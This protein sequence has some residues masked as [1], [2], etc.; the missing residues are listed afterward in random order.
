MRSEENEK[1]LINYEMKI[2]DENKIYILWH[3]T[4]LLDRSNLK[5]V[6][7]LHIEYD[8][9]EHQSQN[10]PDDANPFNRAIN[11]NSSKG[12][13]E[14]EYIST[15]MKKYLFNS[16]YNENYVQHQGIFDHVDIGFIQIGCF[17]YPKQRIVHLTHILH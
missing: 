11:S 7:F 13:K 8:S 9:G 17:F 12:R 10:T 15:S 5:H 6:V 3:H 2:N 1:K 14:C 4:I 16:E